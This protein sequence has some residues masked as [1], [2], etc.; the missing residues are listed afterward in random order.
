MINEQ[1]QSALVAIIN[2]TLQ[3]MDTTVS[4]LSAELPDVINQLLLWKALESFLYFLIIGIGGSI[5][6]IYL[7][8]KQFLW[9]KRPHKPGSMYTNWNESNILVLLNI[10]Q[11]LWIIM[12]ANAILSL[13]WL[14]IMVAPKVWLLEYT[15][16]LI[17]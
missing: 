15:A 4:F 14:Q 5:A 8:W 16:K 17:K 6:T 1:L 11:S 10:F 2:R 9:W 7:N 13:D 3:G 12:I